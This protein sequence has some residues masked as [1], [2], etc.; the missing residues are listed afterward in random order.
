MRKKSASFLLVMS[1]LVFGLAGCGD[2]SLSLGSSAASSTPVSSSPVSSSPISSSPI[3]SSQESSSS[4]STAPVVEKYAVT[5]NEVTG[6]TISIT[7]PAEGTSFAAGTNVNFKVTITDTTMMV[8]TIT[9]EDT[10][11]SDPVTNQAGT[12]VTCAFTMP[13]KAVAVTVTLKKIPVYYGITFNKDIVG[14]KLAIFAEKAVAGETINVY[15]ETLEGYEL[16]KLTS[17]V[18]DLAFKTVHEG[19]QFSFVMPSADVSI[20]AEFAKKYLVAEI[21]DVSKSLKTLT[22][23]TEGEHIAEG[24]TIDLTVEFGSTA[25]ASAVYVTVNN[26]SLEMTPVTT[27]GSSDYYS[28]Y[29]CSFVMPN[30]DVHVYVTRN[31]TYTSETGH[32]VN[33][34]NNENVYVLGFTSGLKYSSVSFNF[35]N[36]DGFVV[37]GMEYRAVGAAETDAWT[38]LSFSGTSVYSPSFTSDTDIRINTKTCNVRTVQ[39]YNLANVQIN[40]GEAKN[41]VNVGDTY[42]INNASLTGFHL[43]DVAFVGGVSNVT[44]TLNY[45]SGNISFTVPEGTDPIVIY[46]KTVANGTITYTEPAEENHIAS[47]SIRKNSYST[48]EITSAAP[49]DMVYVY[50]KADD[51]YKVV[52]MKAMNGTAEVTTSYNKPYYGDAYFSFTM[53]ANG[54]VTLSFGTSAVRNVSSETVTGGKITLNATSYGVGETASFTVS[55][56]TVFFKVK[57]VVEKTHE[58]LE[59]T[60]S[61]N[62]GSF[63]MPDYDVVLV[64]S[65]EA[66][67]GVT[68]SLTKEGLPTQI[69]TIGFRGGQ[70]NRTIDY[71]VANVGDETDTNVYSQEFLPG[72]NVSVSVTF[73]STADNATMVVTSKAE[74]EGGENVT[75]SYEPSY[76]NGGRASYSFVATDKT[77]SVSFTYKANTPLASTVTNDVAG[78]TLTYK[79]RGAEAAD[80]STVYAGDAVE[81][82]MAGTPASGKALKL[83]VKDASRGDMFNNYTTTADGLTA[84]FTANNAFTVTV[85]E[86]SVFNFTVSQGETTETTGSLN[87]NV[88]DATTYSTITYANGIISGTKISVTLQNYYSVPV[89]YVVKCGE[90]EITTGTI[91]ARGQYGPSSAYLNAFVVDADVT[92]AFTF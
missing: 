87:V 30:K 25:Y 20:S 61:G 35:Y 84:S 34:I 15:L 57:D 17:N 9:C 21:K 63:V 58:D 56:E 7:S 86:V 53:P 91:P 62:S 92:V 85:S 5:F 18:K 89:N 10:Y 3:S 1:A 71:N 60:L 38:A 52:T 40:Y 26:Q 47:V 59:I 27:S 80:L 48:E 44:N 54:D 12:E 82:K 88:Q 11:L 78:V 90:T 49:N 29:T 66:V 32:V 43:S 76:L 2:S 37:T 14:G 67:A 41:T 77:L 45:G 46:F 28:Q 13:S 23:I 73:N 36:M 42:N 39:Y 51:N 81:I 4:S 72:E 83:V 75:A 16:T 69:K 33:L 24:K 65:F 55:T 22:G 79:V 50:P 8:D 31:G 64:P 19:E 68:F 70:S 6:A 74:T